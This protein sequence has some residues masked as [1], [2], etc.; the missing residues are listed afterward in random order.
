LIKIIASRGWDNNNM[1]A[2]KEEHLRNL[3][4][5]RMNRNHNEMSKKNSVLEAE[6]AKLRENMKDT[7]EKYGA[8]TKKC[9]EKMEEMQ[10]QFDDTKENLNAEA[11][12][13]AALQRIRHYNAVNE[14][15]RQLETMYNQKVDENKAQHDALM[16]EL[17][18]ER[19]QVKEEQENMK[20][21][22]EDEF[23]KM[24]EERNKL[25]LEMEQTRVK[26]K[27]DLEDLQVR[28][29][30]DE[31][32]MTIRLVMEMDVEREKMMRELEK[33]R[34]ELDEQLE[35]EFIEK[36]QTCNDEIEEYKKQTEL[37]HR[38]QLNEKMKTLEVEIQKLEYERMQVQQE[39]EK[40]HE[41]EEQFKQKEANLMF[42]QREQIAELKKKEE[43]Q[44][45]EHEQRL[46]ELKKKE[47]EQTA[48]H[49]EK[50]QLLKQKEQQQTEVF[51]NDMK[52]LNE[53]RDQLK[54]QVEEEY[55]KIKRHE[56]EQQSQFLM[57]MK[58]EREKFKCQ[59]DKEREEANQVIN[60]QHKANEEAFQKSSQ[61]L[62]L[63]FKA[64]VAEN[65][66]IHNS[67]I[68]RLNEDR[69]REQEKAKQH[70]DELTNS[71]KKLEAEYA[72]VIELQLKLKNEK[73]RVAAQAKTDAEALRIANEAEL[74][75]KKRENDRLFNSMLNNQ[76]VSYDAAMRKLNDEIDKVNENDFIRENEH[77]VLLQK[78]KLELAEKIKQ[79]SDTF[80]NAKMVLES[81]L[82][83]AIEKINQEREQ[84]KEKMRIEEERN[85]LHQLEKQKMKEM[86]EQLEK[87]RALLLDKAREDAANLRKSNMEEMSQLKLDQ[88][89]K[90]KAI[91]AQHK[92][93]FDAKMHEQNTE[94]TKLNEER[95][96]LVKRENDIRNSV[97]LKMQS[98]HNDF[99]NQRNNLTQEMNEK[100]NAQ[101]ESNEQILAEKKQQCH[102]ELRRL[103]AKRQ[104][105]YDE[106]MRKL[107]DE[108]D[109]MKE[110]EFI[111]EN[112]HAEILHKTKMELAERMKE[113]SEAFAR[114]KQ[115][116][117]F[118]FN[119]AMDKLNE[120]RK[121]L[122][123]KLE[124]ENADILTKQ[125]LEQ[126]ATFNTMVQNHKN[127]YDELIR[128]INED[129]KTLKSNLEDEYNALVNLHY[130]EHEKL[131]KEMNEE[132]EK[133]NMQFHQKEMNLYA[134]IDKTNKLQ[135]D[136]MKS[137]DEL[138][139]E[140]TALNEL[141]E[142]LTI[143]HN[144]AMEKIREM[145][146]EFYK[147]Q[148]KMNEENALLDEK[149]KTLNN[150]LLNF[151]EEQ[152][153]QVKYINTLIN[154]IDRV[155]HNSAIERASLIKANDSLKRQLEE[156]S[157]YDNVN[158]AITSNFAYFQLIDTLDFK[159]KRVMIYSH[160]SK[161]EE[162]E[163]YN[164]LTIETIERH[165]DYVIILTNCSTKWNISKPNYNKFYILNYDLK[166]DF[167]NY[168]LFI[169]QNETKLMTASSLFLINDSFVVVDVN[170]FG[171]CV[172][173][174]FDMKIQKYDFI[175]L[176]SSHENV[177]HVQSYFLCFNASILPTVIDYFKTTGLPENHDAA[178]SKYELKIT[179][180]LINA[181]FSHYAFV[182]NDD[183]P[184]PLNTTCCKWTDVLEK[185]GIVKR[186]HFF[187]KYAYRTM[188]MSDSDIREV[189]DKNSYNKHF[190]DF[191]KYN[192]IKYLP[193]PA[194]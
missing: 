189:A 176:T 103:N 9:N 170:A 39:Y 77:A 145:Y 78:T 136:L 169:L 166:S 127:L 93:E 138:K 115:E 175:G 158:K 129:R 70:V 11:K 173:T 54:K 50:L 171:R 123:G 44:I 155:K 17:N 43:K 79:N 188:A 87:E 45:A 29:N 12:K 94:M 177:F 30:N 3:E 53:E 35:K 1:S 121:E 167:R 183:M 137:K 144:A 102:D 86:Q 111:R 154:E 18:Q 81:K 4:I 14:I 46:A 99:E 120:E 96:M 49:K 113:N 23:R 62:E 132:W 5:H 148:S 159:D 143:E 184:R 13:E 151:Q 165:F 10:R 98:L 89:A 22:L 51:M 32:E 186:Q 74:D 90:L 141:R 15:K 64:R 27:Q 82:N 182:S 133:K 130:D 55:E 114:S 21:E 37:A 135:Y 88:D 85:K 156:S 33:N 164:M 110:K 139:T 84:M 41:W 73:D 126:T 25:D 26:I 60:A 95:E 190:I 163:S 118:R 174:I 52:L 47:E 24:K 28:M 31:Q 56:R 72:K 116:L 194:K 63:K 161:R 117:D 66:A 124:A 34:K 185:T 153:S 8:L 2:A 65:L 172:K 76:K 40:R 100:L 147:K 178:I 7:A 193:L 92:N 152:S 125:K 109:K 122:K 134:S 61:E 80:A 157:T 106:S 59:M 168:G 83:S 91:I 97:M 108:I 105:T 75:E 149:R 181:G 48:I 71:K 146:E 16:Q 20:R 68:Q 19:S 150:D 58:A 101:L 6:C 42:W 160:Y 36:K 179:M 107:S 112:E 131:S 128:K 38:E 180:H 67:T 162:V 140:K 191:L 69:E 57:R 187:K 119:S 104:A 192:H 142:R